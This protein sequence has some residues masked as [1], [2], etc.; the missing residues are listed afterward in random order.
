MAVDP[1]VMAAVLEGEERSNGRRPRKQRRA[2]R[3]SCRRKRYEQFNVALE[4]RVKAM[5]K[6]IAAYEGVSASGAMELLAATG[7]RE[8]VGGRLVF[9]DEVRASDGNGP[10]W[11]VA[12]RGLDDL[13]LKLEGTL[14]Q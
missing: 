1:S 9:G 4:P 7:I 2:G 11:V 5:V 13:V 8:Y 3:G 14:R 12:L 6:R 10:D